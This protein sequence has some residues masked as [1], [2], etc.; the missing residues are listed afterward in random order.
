MYIMQARRQWEY[1]EVTANLKSLTVETKRFHIKQA[2]S[3]RTNYGMEIR[4]CLKAFVY[5][6]YFTLLCISDNGMTP[7]SFESNSTP[8]KLWLPSTRE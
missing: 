1:I 6:I 5:I 4:H 2:V 3:S 8:T 7:P